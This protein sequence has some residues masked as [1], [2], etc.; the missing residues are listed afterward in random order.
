MKKRRSYKLP[1]EDKEVDRNVIEE[2][3]EIARWAPSA[4]NGQY[5]RYVILEA[6]GLRKTLIHK[7][8]QKLK[9]DLE[10]DGKPKDFI[11][12]KINNTRKNFIQAPILILLCLDIKE[13]EKYPDD[14]RLQNEFILGVQSIS[15]S[16]T[17]LLLAFE[18]KNLAACWY[19]A[20]LFA[21]SIIK[22]TLNL[23]ESYIPMAF[24]TVGYPLRKIKAPTRKE[25]Q[26]IIFK[27]K[28]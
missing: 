13:L 23:P 10:K 4:H 2:C 22:Q 28:V 25:L 5:W 3:I 16:A 14:E 7:M 11:E 24:F 6:N 12:Q 20:P 26:D 27:P 1:F 21:K 15:T 9:N 17:Y 8:N 19:C 18:I